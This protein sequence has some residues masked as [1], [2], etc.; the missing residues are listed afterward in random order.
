MA[1]PTPIVYSG[2][3]TII[4]TGPEFDHTLAKYAH[5]IQKLWPTWIQAKKDD[6]L[7]MVGNDKPFKGGGSYAGLNHAHLGDDISI[8]YRLE[9]RDP[10]KLKLYGFYSHED[11]G[12][13]NPAKNKIQQVV[14]KRLTTQM[15]EGGS[16]NN[17]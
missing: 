6:P 15:F 10:R 7:R 5:R 4:V 3:A 16:V 12:T 8:V 13:G 14:G 11:L 2:P 9:G 17:P 1:K